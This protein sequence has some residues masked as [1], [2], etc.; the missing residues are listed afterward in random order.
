[1]RV[2]RLALPVARP[3]FRAM[4][5]PISLCSPHG[6]QL[7]IPRPVFLAP[8]DGVT[9]ALFRRLVV[10]EGGVG[11]V[12]SEFARISVTALPRR[13]L[14]KVMGSPLVGVAN[15]LQIMLADTRHL[16][17]TVQHAASIGADFLD[18]N[19]GC[20]AK[21]VVSHCA[22]S[23]LLA[24]PER[25]AQ[26]VAATVAATE[27]PVT[28]KL[29][30]GIDSAD[31]LE[32]CL[33]AVCGA[34]ATLVALHARLRVQN[35]QQAACWEWLQ[36]AAAH[37]AGRWP[38]VVLVGNGGI[39]S[40]KQAR[41]MASFPGVHG[42]MVG[43]AALADP[44]IFRQINGGNP[45]SPAEAKAFIGRYAAA[46]RDRMKPSAALGRL[47]QLIKYWR[48]GDVFSQDDAQRRHLLRARSW[49]ELKAW[50]ALPV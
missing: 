9:D 12:C 20:P 16:A 3:T 24:H 6:R 22:G 32:E 11:V 38:G 36:R 33:D 44:W 23:A 26:L 35:Y 1:M 39:D 19:F 10:A 5:E 28:A 27:L 30:V 43:Q 18:L 37:M 4:L 31:H 21:R 46:L 50:L 40:V 2:G 34:G 41:A 17:S 48:A 13:N 7:V 47:K 49:Q 15:G 14:V 29:R 8:M 42:I 45:A 25:M